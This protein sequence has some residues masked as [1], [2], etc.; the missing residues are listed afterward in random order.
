MNDR[1]INAST[2]DSYMGRWSRLLGPRFV[3]W[4]AV[5]PGARWLDIGCGTGSLSEAICSGASPALV[6]GCDPSAEFIE[7]ARV[8]HSD[9]RLEFVVAGAGSLP[10]RPGGF[11][12]ITSSL[13]LNL[14]PDP[15]A[16]VQEMR[17][18]AAPGALISACVWD[19]A[20]GTEFL[21]RFWDAAAALDPRAA[22]LDE[23]RRFPICNPGPLTKLFH[24]AG[25]QRVS[26]EP[27]E[28][29]TA[30]GDFA[31]FW[32]PFLGGTGPAPA[33]VANLEPGTRGALAER[34]DRSLPREP[35][36]AIRLVARAWAVRGT[37]G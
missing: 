5:P 23:G 37:A 4:L 7:H 36:G 16:A 17:D 19:Y 1:W 30:F 3:S 29:E 24:G 26:C 11:N 6:V 12:S 21:R 22:D 15:A 9:P 13:V 31:D 10:T 8:S 14:F 34:L 18:A 27:I 35:D 2:Y 25:L 20:D 28:I 33:Y 32:T